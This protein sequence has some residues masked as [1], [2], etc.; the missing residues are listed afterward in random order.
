MVAIINMILDLAYIFKVT[1]AG[2]AIYG[3]YCILIMVRFLGPV[4]GVIRNLLYKVNDTASV[5]DLK[6]LKW[7]MDDYKKS[8]MVLYSTIPFTYLIGTYRLL[9]FKNFAKQIRIGLAID[10]FLNA[11]AF[12]IMQSVNNGLLNSRSEDVG[13]NFEF[14][15]L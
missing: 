9:N 1:F 15:P 11:I 8:G 14:S 5:S 2:S 6:S 4:A 7:K 3:F 13:Y 10:F 12:L